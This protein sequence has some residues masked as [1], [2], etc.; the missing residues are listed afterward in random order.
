MHQYLSVSPGRQIVVVHGLG[1]MGKTQLA[2]AYV[3]RH[4]NDYSATIWL[5]ARDEASLKQ[6]FRI[7]ALRISREYPTLNYLQ[8]AALD[9]DCDAWPAV[10]RWLEEPK[11]DRWLLIYDNYDHPSMRICAGA[12]PVSDDCNPGQHSAVDDQAPEAYDI[13]QYLP[14]IDQGM[15]IVT[16]RS[17]IVQI[18]EPLRLQKLGNEEDGLRILET[19]SGRKGCQEGT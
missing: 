8:A 14:N 19:T 13:R 4:R 9:K 1:G 6:S 3:K 10:K 11:N 17:S 2:I 16:T 12:M 5:N 18:G 15:V 7:A